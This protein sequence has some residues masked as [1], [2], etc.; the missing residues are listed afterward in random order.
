L[1]K[2]ALFQLYHAE[3]LYFFNEVSMRRLLDDCGFE[4]LDIIADPLC[5]DNFRSAEMHQGRLGN[6]ALA[7]TY[8]A[9]RALHRGH[10][11]KVIARRRSCSVAVDGPT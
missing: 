9:G 1:Y 4:T 8:F 10:G 5:W 2:K 6:L 7:L 3:H 11:M